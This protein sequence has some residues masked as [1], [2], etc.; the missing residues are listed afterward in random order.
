MPNLRPRPMF[1][2]D[3][4]FWPRVRGEV[5]P[6]CLG[7]MGTGKTDRDEWIVK[8]PK[9]G[10]IRESCRHV[11]RED[12]RRIVSLLDAGVEV[13]QTDEERESSEPHLH[14]PVR[15]V[16]QLVTPRYTMDDLVLAESTKEGLLDALAEL[17]HKGLMY[18]RWGLK[19]VVKKTKGQPPV[20]GTSGDREDDGRGGNRKRTR[21]ADARRE[22][23]AAREHVGRGDGEEHRACVPRRARGRRRPVLRRGRCGLPTPRGHGY[24]LDEP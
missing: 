1:K 14:E 2:Y 8:C 5:R 7:G 23:R 13:S 4:G 18:R 19:K 6:R 20:R 24:A 11:S 15:P 3:T 21:P 22:L 12:V 10:R 17:R 16:A 9:C